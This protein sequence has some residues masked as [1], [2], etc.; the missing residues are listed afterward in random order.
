[1]ITSSTRDA[2]SG[3]PS[4][5]EGL[6][7]RAT[8]ASDLPMCVADA[9]SADHVLVWVNPA[10]ERVTGYRSDDILGLN[11]RFL[12][13]PD[14]DRRVT[15][16]ISAALAAGRTVTEVMLNYRADGSSF[17]NELVVS[18]MLDRAG[19]L[20]HFVGVQADVTDRIEA[21]AGRRSALGVVERANSRLRVLA[22]IHRQM[23][24]R[25]RLG[26]NILEALPR[27][28]ASEFPDWVFVA[29]VDKRHRVGVVAAH[30]ANPRR[31][32]FAAELAATVQAAAT[33]RSDGPFGRAVQQMMGH[34]PVVHSLTADE[35]RHSTGIPADASRP[36]QGAMIVGVPLLSR[37]NLIG[38]LALV[39]DGENSFD[40]EDVAAIG[41]L[42]VRVSMALDIAGLYAA[43]HTAALTLQRSL[44]PHVP[45]VEGFEVA[46][47]YQP[48]ER[49]AEV[50]GDWYDVLD[51][52]R[53]GIGIAIG[54]VMGHDLAAAAAMGQ[55]RSVLRSYAWSGDSPAAVL[56]RLDELVQAL[57]MAALATCFYAT[58]MPTDTPS[59]H[60]LTYASAGHLPPLLRRADGRVDRLDASL[61]SPIGVRRG[62][63]PASEGR[64]LVAAGD[65]LV[66]YTD[67]LVETR[68][69]DVDTGITALVA[70]LSAAPRHLD[71]RQLCDLLMTELRE[72]S[73]AEDD[74]CLLVLRCLATGPA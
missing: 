21:A 35:V 71:A 33:G 72:S 39:R 15:R 43:E 51:F 8:M 1:M 9:R 41:D 64:V 20:T 30:H 60:E 56:A 61:T 26:H 69:R 16:R 32:R 5:D 11:C 40:G 52:P 47:T 46:A 7:F 67:G 6:Q 18:P 74:T 34:E 49:S 36:D 44:L 54:D 65:V 14:P 62:S 68:A 63:G 58:I 31:A 38:L 53:A 10:F 17:W 55:L 42:G 3:P 27:I 48:A 28:V 12:Q 22:S 37:G 45:Q 2:S 29:G 59:G 24:A 50:G 4:V 66:L 19:L 73:A 13:G 23:D 25:L 57:G 70:A